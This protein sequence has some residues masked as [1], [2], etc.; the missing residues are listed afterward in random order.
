[1]ELPTRQVVIPKRHTVGYLRDMC[2]Y[3]LVIIFLFQK[4]LFLHAL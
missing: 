2:D 4:A 3:A 1:M